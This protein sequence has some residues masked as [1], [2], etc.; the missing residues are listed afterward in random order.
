MLHRVC[1]TLIVLLLVTG[2]LHGQDKKDWKPHPLAPS[3]PLL[4][5]EEYARIEKIIDVF[6]DYDSGLL[7]GGNG[8]KILAD[9]DALG[10]EA[11]PS[12]IEGLNK[13]ANLKSS[14][15]AV[16]IGKKLK[17]L[18][19]ASTDGQLL[20]FARES[21]GIGVTIP[22]HM[23]VIKDLKV[24]CILRKS[25]LQQT[26]Q[27]APP[28]KKAVKAMNTEELAKAV[29]KEKGLYL[30]QILIELEQRPGE[31]V[32]LALGSAMSHPEADIRLLAQNLLL[33]HLAGQGPST[34]KSLLKH[35][36]DEV[37]L[38]VVFLIG[39]K[40]LAWGDE[41]I[42]SLEDSSA[43]VRQVAHQALV[44]LSGKDFGPGPGASAS[45]KAQSI[46]AWRHWW[47]GQSASSSQNK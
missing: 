30:K 24:A 17:K 7:P 18:L 31:Q 13:A 37:R 38:G 19:V 12:L 25:H 45:Q 32:L 4:T 16:I 41:L 8:K 40:K 42:D 43:K 28:G 46:Q 20:D 5:D 47:K 2:S 39:S 15:P 1:A 33:K 26:G 44:Q 11:I 23:N 27:L 36:S 3:L 14:C 9:F 10:P 29:D 34:L 6:I 22:R 21:V 35:Q